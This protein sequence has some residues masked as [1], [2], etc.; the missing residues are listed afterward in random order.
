MEKKADRQGLG[1]GLSAL[2]ADVNL[3]ATD[4][5]QT[6]PQRQ[7]L[8]IPIERLLPNPDQPRRLFAPDQLNDCLLYTSRCV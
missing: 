4:D 7:E 5:V 1:R 2:M 3:G 6:G 8:R